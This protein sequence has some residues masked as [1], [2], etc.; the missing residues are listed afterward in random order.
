[1]PKGPVNNAM[2]HVKSK[3]LSVDKAFLMLEENAIKID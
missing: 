3:F 1:M 2:F